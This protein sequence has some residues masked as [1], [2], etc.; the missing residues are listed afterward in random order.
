MLVWVTQH[1]NMLW[2]FSVQV[3]QWM[4]HVLFQPLSRR[5]FYMFVTSSVFMVPCSGRH[6]YYWIVQLPMYNHLSTLHNPILLFSYCTLT[7]LQAFIVTLV[8]VHLQKH[9]CFD[10]WLGVWIWLQSLY[11]ANECI[12]YVITNMTSSAD[13]EEGEPNFTALCTALR[14]L[15]G[16]YFPPCSPT[17]VCGG[18][19]GQLLSRVLF[20]LYW[21]LSFP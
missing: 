15:L 2:V 3:F 18:R 6:R 10:V 13:A 7:L 16:F 12:N 17:N 20:S 4:L 11:W 14:L 8:P 21:F 1:S 9:L 5:M 19:W